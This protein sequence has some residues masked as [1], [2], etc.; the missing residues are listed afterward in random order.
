MARDL[1]VGVITLVHTQPGFFTSE[2]MALVQAIADQA[3]IAVLN[4]RLYADSQRQARVMTWLAES[5]AGI[6]VSLNLEDVLSG[7]MRQI[8]QTLNVQAASLALLDTKDNSLVF[9]A[10]TGWA[11]QYVMK[12]RLQVGQGVAGWV[13]QEGRGIVIQDV[14]ADMRFD[15]E[16]DRRTGFQTKSIA[17]APIQ[18][19]GEVIGVLEAVN[20]KSGLFDPDALLVLTGIGSL[21][22]TAIRHA[23][24]F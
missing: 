11:G 3:G 21:A 18:Y 22:G 12:S 24:L 19:R 23:Q 20:P 10:A 4:A 2:H 1:L 15:P 14:S 6:S 5:A 7:I 8:T 13:F 17:C 16:T 9:R